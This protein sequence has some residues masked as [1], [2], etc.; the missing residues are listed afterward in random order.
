MSEEQIKELRQKF[1]DE[2]CRKY[3]SAEIVY[4]PPNDVFQ[5]FADNFNQCEHLVLNKGVCVAC[6]QKCIVEDF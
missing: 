3:P 2:C 6:G 4:L 1:F 5:W